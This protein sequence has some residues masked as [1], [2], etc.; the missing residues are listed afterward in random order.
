MDASIENP[1]YTVA[2]YATDGTKY[3]LTPVLQELDF[4][5]QENQIA[6]CVTITIA[7]FK[8]GGNWLS[9]IIRVR[10]RVYIFAN[11]GQKQDEV[12]RGFVWTQY[13]I[14]SESGKEIT[15]KCYDHLIYLQESESSYYFSKGK[16]T[17]A[18]VAQICKNWGIAYNYTYSSITH[19]KLVLRGPIYDMFTNELLD[20]V[21]ERNGSKY[22]IRSAKDV[23]YFMPIG[24]NTTIYTINWSNNA[25]QTRS[26]QTM[27]GVVTKI[28]ILGKADSND[29]QP[30]V[31]TVTGNTSLYGT[32][33]KLQDKDEDT[34]LENAKKEANTTI[35]ENGTP[36]WEYTVEAV[37]IP[38]IRKGDK[39]NVAAGTL[40]GSFIVLSIDRSISNKSKKMTLTLELA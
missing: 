4:S 2:L 22:I 16:Q 10:Q 40:K 1:I 31:A 39:V 12:F 34:S 21:K 29:H 14:E 33:Q 6:Q 38:W 9:N 30:Y 35:K 3:D 18:V 20:K 27:D 15:M 26:E 37:D 17:S 5:E 8:S 13:P 19:D 7:N 36:K 28:R 24:T 32:I 23:V 25:V 11:D